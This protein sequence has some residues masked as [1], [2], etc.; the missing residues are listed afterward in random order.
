[1]GYWWIALLFVIYV[2]LK[3]RHDLHM[4]QQNSYR[5]KRYLRWYHSWYKKELCQA[6]LTLLLPLIG[7][8][9]H[10]TVF[11]VLFGLALLFLVF[12]HKYRLVPQ[13]KAL[14]M[15]PRA[16][17]LYGVSIFLAF[18]FALLGMLTVSAPKELRLLYWLLL[19]LGIV[20]SFVFVL[21]ANVLLHPV[22]SA[23]NRR[24][25]NEAKDI[26]LSMPNLRIIGVTGSFGKTSCKM[27]LGSVLGDAF[28]TLVT[29][30]SFNTP[31]GVT[32]V[33]RE[34]LRPIHELFVVE[35]GAKQRGDIAELCQ[36]VQPQIGV[37]TAIGEQHLETFKNLQNIIDT[38]FELIEALPPDG[39]A[40]LNFENPY[41]RE[42]SGRAHCRVVSYGLQAD[43]DYWAEDIHYDS[44]GCR[45]TVH[46]RAGET[47]AM[48][49]ALLGRH[50][51]LNILAACACAVEMGL[52]L[53]QVA[54]E[55]ALLAPVEHRLQLLLNPGG[56]HVI[57]DAFNANP[58]GAQ[59]A[60][61]V[62]AS[63]PTGK[64]ILVTPGMVEL[65]PR[66]YQ[67]N[68][69][70]AQAAAAVCDVIILVGREHSK[71]LQDGL[72]AANYPQA[73]YFVANDLNDA[74]LYLGGI[75]SPGDT[76]LFENDL[77]DTYNE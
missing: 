49:T 57:D 64:K 50:S 47:R 41:I 24:Y 31:L 34:S 45:F 9:L 13:K 55:A 4:F 46:T 17:R 60:L 44:R 42:N 18:C 62:L 25:L 75:V 40:V 68:F 11:Q 21:L 19:S 6:E 76:V 36:L 5:A 28:T 51:I 2:S 38:K 53:D 56:Y 20:F 70:F 22:E 30:G 35:M 52:S 8:L 74:R 48:H 59:A 33:V 72:A 26:L 39:L 16:K 27:I 54:K 61:E 10:R 12:T 29:P 71:P 66:E 73:A 3:M 63:M 23:I 15:T 69:E 67:L 43:C 1:M 37:L 77:P 65:G 7:L 32:R 14:V 58:A